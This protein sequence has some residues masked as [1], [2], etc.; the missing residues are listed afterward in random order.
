M[1][2]TSV[3]SFV[4]SLIYIGSTVAFYAITSLLTVALLQ[5]YMFSIGSILWRRIYLPDTLPP[6]QFSLGRFGIPV[7]AAAVIYCAWA[8][9]WS[10][11]PI[12]TPVTAEG[13]NWAAVI[14]VGVLIFAMLWYAIR[15]RHFYEGPVVLV[16]PQ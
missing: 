14:F 3:I 2:V 12:A 10:F 4:L 5:C 16:R 1:I 13:F 7:N 15:A 11:W 9:F 6:T 8:F